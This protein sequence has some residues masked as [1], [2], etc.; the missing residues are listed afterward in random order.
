MTLKESWAVSLISQKTDGLSTGSVLPVHLRAMTPPTIVLDW[1]TGREARSETGQD[2]LL[3]RRGEALTSI[4]SFLRPHGSFG[5][6]AEPTSV[7]SQ[8]TRLRNGKTV[9]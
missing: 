6:S 8:A 1:G 7:P 9:P 5:K 3:G 4:G 2:G